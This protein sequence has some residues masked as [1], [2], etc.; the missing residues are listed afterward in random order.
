[1]A[2]Y[3]PSK[4]AERAHQ[5]MHTLSAVCIATTLLTIAV[6]LL[7]QQQSSAAQ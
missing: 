6:P 7:M 2:L 4:N 3:M 5:L 1:M